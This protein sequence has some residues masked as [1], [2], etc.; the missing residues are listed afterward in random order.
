[1]ARGLTLIELLLVVAV[2]AMV[3]AAVSVGF[4]STARDATEAVVSAEMRNI[5]DAFQRFFAD[6]RPTEAQLAEIRRFGL[7]PLTTPEHRENWG[8]D[9]GMKD[10]GKDYRLYDAANAAG[11]SGPYCVAEGHRRIDPTLPGQPEVASGGVEVP[12]IIDPEGNHYR[13]LAPQ[14]SGVFNYNRLL[15]VRLAVG[16]GEGEIQDRLDLLI[17]DREALTKLRQ[18]FPDCAFHWLLPARAQR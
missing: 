1:M 13:V 11:W 14:R 10:P 9:P 17:D 7:W 6:C 16:R 5:C 4:G 3:A 12:V 8:V 2:I 15:L 18:V